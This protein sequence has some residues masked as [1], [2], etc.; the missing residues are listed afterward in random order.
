[1]FLNTKYIFTGIT[2][3]KMVLLQTQIS[4]HNIISNFCHKLRGLSDKQGNRLGGMVQTCRKTTNPN[5]FLLHIDYFERFFLNNT[6]D[7][8]IMMYLMDEIEELL[9][10]IFSFHD[11]RGKMFTNLVSYYTSKYKNCNKR[12]IYE[13]IN[14]LYKCLNLKVT[15]F[16]YPTNQV[17]TNE[18]IYRFYHSRNVLIEE[19][20]AQYKFDFLG[21]TRRMAKTIEM[22][23]VMNGIRKDVFNMFGW[24]DNAQSRLF[25]EYIFENDYYVVRNNYFLEILIA[26][27]YQ[28]KGNTILK[29]LQQKIYAFYEPGRVCHH[30]QGFYRHV[31][32]MIY[33]KFLHYST[34]QKRRISNDGLRLTK[35]QSLNLDHIDDHMPFKLLSSPK[36]KRTDNFARVTAFSPLRKRL[37]LVTKRNSYES[38]K[39][40]NFN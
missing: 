5:T 32:T 14:L 19:N 36:R 31:F 3:L 7:E 27:M 29:D 35:C 33:E 4:Y 6:H 8:M 39:K 17:E 40:L 1:M 30:I 28:V 23:D 18:Y 38:A 24:N 2:Y 9:W 37:N 26:F 22:L 25:I 21:H 15:I 20:L 11:S 13:F 16:S 12:N 34:R 10:F